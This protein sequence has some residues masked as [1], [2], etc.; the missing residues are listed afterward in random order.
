MRP[1]WTEA[2]MCLVVDEISGLLNRECN[3]IGSVVGGKVSRRPTWRL[4][5]PTKSALSAVVEG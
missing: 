1:Q 4:R 2:E 3:F 5:N